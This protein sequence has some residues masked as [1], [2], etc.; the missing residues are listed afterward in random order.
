MTYILELHY[1]RLG[2]GAL[3]NVG[4]RLELEASSVTTRQRDVR[5]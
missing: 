5:V 1:C 2:K 4:V 3:V